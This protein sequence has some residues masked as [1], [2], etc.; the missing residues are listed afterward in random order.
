MRKTPLSL[1]R[2]FAFRELE[3]VQFAVIRLAA[4]VLLPENQTVNHSARPLS[5]TVH[6]PAPRMGGQGFIGPRLLTEEAGHKDVEDLVN[7][8]PELM[9]IMP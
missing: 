8:Y 3:P 5:G 1:G 9:K 7:G 2:T 4:M 6:M